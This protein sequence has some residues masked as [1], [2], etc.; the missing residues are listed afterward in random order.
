MSGLE[1]GRGRRRWR[2]FLARGG[3]GVGTGCGASLGPLAF[4]NRSTSAAGMRRL[5]L[6][7]TVRS[8]P[9]RISFARV[10]FRSTPRRRAASRM[11]RSCALGIGRWR[12][13]QGSRSWASALAMVVR[14]ALIA[15]SSSWMPS[16]AESRALRL[17]DT[18][19]RSRPGTQARPS[20]RCRSAHAATF[21]RQDRQ[22][23]FWRPPVCSDR[24]VAPPVQPNC[25]VPRS[26]G[27]SLA[28]VSS[29]VRLC[30]RRAT[31]RHGGP[32]IWE[33]AGDLLGPAP[34]PK[35]SS[36]AH[37]PS[38][39]AGPPRGKKQL[40]LGAGGASGPWYSG[41]ADCCRARCR[42]TLL[43]GEWG[44]RAAQSPRSFRPPAPGR[45]GRRVARASTGAARRQG[46]HPAAVH[47]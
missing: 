9:V 38:R 33:R 20:T 17:D 7:S 24:C 23:S 25:H 16:K 32:S 36:W 11:L 18:T 1:E 44:S 21:R 31:A 46:H 26:A 8:C 10:V 43:G 19:P 45:G 2:V 41:R 39:P 27:A 12:G 29:W 42:V 14:V 22:E 40:A 35:N 4:A 6:V 15:R 34:S 47:P 5:P 37:L 30:R 3:A 28:L 13:G